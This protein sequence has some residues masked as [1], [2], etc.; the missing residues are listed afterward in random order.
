MAKGQARRING[1]GA[2]RR[3]PPPSDSDKIIEAMLACIARQGWRR[4][5]LVAALAALGAA[6]WELYRLAPASAAGRAWLAVLC[7]GLGTAGLYYFERGQ[8]WAWQRRS[9]QHFTSQRRPRPLLAARTKGQVG[10]R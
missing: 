3:L 10:A 2:A 8:K 1:G 9:A 5:G 4:W 6:G 7:V